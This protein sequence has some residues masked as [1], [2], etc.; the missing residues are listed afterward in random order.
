MISEVV[1]L[2]FAALAL[3]AFQRLSG[4]RM[5]RSG[6]FGMGFSFGLVSSRVVGRWGCRVRR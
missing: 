5:L 3:V 1:V 2:S 4:M 6:V